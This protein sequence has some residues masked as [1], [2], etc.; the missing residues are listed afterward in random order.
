MST[1]I[2]G[3]FTVPEAA[4]EIGVTDSLVRRWFVKVDCRTRRSAKKF[5]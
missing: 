2:P 3:Y 5:E 1:E 4:V